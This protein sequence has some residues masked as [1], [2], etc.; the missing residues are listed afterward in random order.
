MS[1]IETL[2]KPFSVEQELLH[3]KERL[4]QGPPTVI[5]IGSTEDTSKIV[6]HIGFLVNKIGARIIVFHGGGPEIDKELQKKG[7]IPEKINGLR[8]TDKETLKIVVDVLDRKN[9]E[10]VHSLQQIGVNAVGYD[11]TSHIIKAAIKDERLGMVGK[12]ICVD[13]RKL[14]G[15]VGNQRVPVVSPIGIMHN[16]N[17]Q[18]LNVNGDESAGAVARAYRANLVLVTDVE[19]VLDPDR[20]LIREISYIRFKEM[21]RKGFITGGMI[22][23]LE[24]AFVVANFGGQATICRESDVLHAFSANPRGTVSMPKQ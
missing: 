17:R 22:P 24:A 9:K 15:D 1:K 11:S 19:G 5:K 16:N 10:L 13:T 2:P 14:G 8:V 23:K 3:N 7:I 6:S 21:Q 20:N 12:V 4:R 18:H